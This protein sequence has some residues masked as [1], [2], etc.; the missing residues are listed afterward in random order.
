MCSNEPCCGPNAIE[1]LHEAACHPRLRSRYCPRGLDGA[2]RLRLT[3]AD[4]AGL[5]EFEA[6][7]AEA[8]LVWRGGVR[9]A[10]IGNSP[11]A[12]TARTRPSASGR[13]AARDGPQAYGFSWLSFRREV[14]L[15]GV[16]VDD[17]GLGKT[18]QVLAFVAA[19][20]AAG[21]LDRPALVWRPRA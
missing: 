4:A 15:G 10:A 8:G 14:G 18:V 16:L 2:G 21:R 7:T 17:M 6:A 20:K 13:A 3:A 9:A 19:E 5:A 1:R 12:G 11:K